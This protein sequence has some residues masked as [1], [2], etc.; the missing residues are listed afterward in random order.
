MNG[1]N[2]SEIETLMKEKAAEEAFFASRITIHARIE[3][4]Q[5]E[6]DVD[7]DD[8]SQRVTNSSFGVGGSADNPAVRSV[9]QSLEDE[10]YP[11]QY[12]WFRRRMTRTRNRIQYNHWYW[13]H[14]HWHLFL[15]HWHCAQ[16]GS[17]VG[18]EPGRLLSM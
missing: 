16:H 10:Y 14:Y 13:A 7:D 3:A 11:G 4:Q 8:E 12:S 18:A 1:N 2:S 15:Y 5:R 9:R 17:T 6:S